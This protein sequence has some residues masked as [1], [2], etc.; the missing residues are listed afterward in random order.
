MH[1]LSR[2]YTRLGHVSLRS[3]VVV[4]SRPGP[5]PAHQR[6]A[7]VP[8]KKSARTVVSVPIVTSKLGGH[9]CGEHGSYPVLVLYTSLW[10]VEHAAQCL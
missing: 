7:L 9:H 1:G 4:G 6:M 3:H 5:S 8:D 2:S 10:K